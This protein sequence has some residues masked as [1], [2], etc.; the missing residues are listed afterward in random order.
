MD[1]NAII[2]YYYNDETDSRLRNLLLTHSRQVK[3]TALEVCYRHPELK[4]DVEIVEAGAMLHDIG[5]I[6]C[7]AP[8]IYCYGTEPYIK[9][10]IIGSGMIAQY[11]Q[12]KKEDDILMEKL[13]RIC[14]RHTG[15]GLPGQ[16]PETI[17]EKI[18]CYADKFFS[19]THPEK[20]KTYQA[21][22]HSLEKFGQ[23]GLI[24][25]SQWHEK[26]K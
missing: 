8:D 18:V 15:T 23:E 20:K 13:M 14:A 1:Y 2:D 24:I 26:F 12:D 4:A 5:I 10:G 17:E 11:F 6:R 21:A 22:V 16:E 9:H 19:K 25:F 3:D 7:N